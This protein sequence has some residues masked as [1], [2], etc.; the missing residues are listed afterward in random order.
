[1]FTLLSL[2]FII[3][4][5]FFNSFLYSNANPN[6]DYMIAGTL[7]GLAPVINAAII[8]PSATT[9]ILMGIRLQAGI[10]FNRYGWNQQT[11]TANLR[12]AL[13]TSNFLYV[14]NSISTNST[15][16]GNA[17]GRVEV[18]TSATVIIPV[19]DTYY[20]YVDSSN[21]AAT[22]NVMYGA[23]GLGVNVCNYIDSV[24]PFALTAGLPLPNGTVPFKVATGVRVSGSP[25]TT[26]TD[27]KVGALANMTYQQFLFGIFLSYTA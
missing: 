24:A 21:G 19:T 22:A 10:N 23:F 25:P 27:L 11:G 4:N 26:N 13:Y 7:G 1:M 14:A 17:G 16:P 6:L 9:F 20:I 8:I 2:A 18:N 12:C 3:G 15:A 5:S